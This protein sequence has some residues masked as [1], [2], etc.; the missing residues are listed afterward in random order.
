MFWSWS[1]YMESMKLCCGECIS[2]L[3]RLVFSNGD[4]KSQR[5]R[6]F[7]HI[8]IPVHHHRSS[9]FILH[10]LFCI[11]LHSSLFILH[12]SA[13]SFISLHRSSF[14]IRVHIYIYICECIIVHHHSSSIVPRSS[15]IAHRSSFIVHHHSS[16]Q[17]LFGV[18]AT[19]SY[20]HFP[21]LWRSCIAAL[22]IV[23]RR[24]IAPLR[25]SDIATRTPS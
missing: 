4:R 18:I 9:L 6:Q 2:P 20:V 11:V 14:T 5:G 16:T 3:Y 12:R 1:R 7:M 23:H 22:A 19:V 25:R 13:S 21:P 10:R 15:F 17:T 8:H 24:L